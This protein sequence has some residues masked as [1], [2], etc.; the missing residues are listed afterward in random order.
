MLYLSAGP[1]G[2]RTTMVVLDASGALLSGSDGVLFRMGLEG[3]P[4]PTDCD[5]PALIH[6]ESVGG[7][8]EPDGS[9]RG[10]RWRSVAVDD[11]R[12]EDLEWELTR[13]DPSPAD[14]SGLRSLLAEL[15]RRSSP[16]SG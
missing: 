12:E 16:P 6:Q 9:F 8:F 11:G 7:R 5:V 4:P 2:S 13:S 15:I 10:T 14:A 1:A 3:A